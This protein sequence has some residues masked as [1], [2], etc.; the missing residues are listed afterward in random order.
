MTIE[1]KTF[2]EMVE[3]LKSARQFIRIASRR[4]PKSIRNSDKWELVKADAAIGNALQ[5]ATQD[6]GY[7][8]ADSGTISPMALGAFW[9]IGFVWL[10][11]HLASSGL[12]NALAQIG[13]R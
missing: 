8:L 6:S 9:I 2:D 13:G 3:A 7:L 10:M 5:K 12:I 11:M 4:F 1:Q